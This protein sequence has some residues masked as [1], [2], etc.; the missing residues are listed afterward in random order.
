M[1]L[2]I[3]K[4]LAL[5]AVFAVVI[6]SCDENEETL[7]F[8][9]AENNIV[10]PDYPT[11]SAT[12]TTL[13]N[14]VLDIEVDGSASSLDVTGE[15]GGS[16]GSVAIASG[17]GTFTRT[18]AELGNPS[19]EE[20]SFSDGE[21][22]RLFEITI[23]NPASVRGTTSS[24]VELD[25]VFSI[26]FDASSVNGVIDGYSL[27]IKN[28]S[29]AVF[30]GVPNSSDTNT[31]IELEDSLAFTANNA[32][33][34]IGDTIFYKV[35]FTS[36]SL[37]DSVSGSLM[38]VPVSLGQ[39]GSVALRT[40]D[41]VISMGVTDS[42]NNAFNFSALKVMADSVLA[43]NV[44]SADVSLALNAGLLDLAAG[45]GSN[46]TFL[47][48]PEDFN[49]SDVTYEAVRDSMNAV[50]AVPVSTVTNIESLYSN[51][52]IFVQIGNIPQSGNAAA[53]NRKYA[54]IQI[55]GVTKADAGVTSEVTFDYVAPTQPE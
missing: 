38:V 7:A 28:G 51:A 29:N 3:N 33:Y 19:S 50:G 35:E 32:G 2:Y 5:L 12:F 16:F 6:F 54:A 10:F 37:V 25:S 31:G 27:F 8:V 41:Y 21:T 55:T 17:T 52:V 26:A 9:E 44:D 53:D 48:A 30:P 46:T 43:T 1:K 42:L 18:L 40:P 36:A 34:S 11:Y 24:E 47:V 23:E 15:D 20:L 14:V 4:S 49:F 22:N 45:T 39:S 13:D